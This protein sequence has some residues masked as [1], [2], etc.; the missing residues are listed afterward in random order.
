MSPMRNATPKRMSADDLRR[1]AGATAR[2]A[3]VADDR[4]RLERRAASTS[5]TSGTGTTS[6]GTAS[7]WVA[8]I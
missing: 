3:G 1:G 6:V 8:G 5:T 4:H 2:D 7:T